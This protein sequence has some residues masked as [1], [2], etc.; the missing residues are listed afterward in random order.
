MKSW[1]KKFCVMTQDIPIATRT[2]LLDQNS[3]ATLSKSVVTE[4][5]KKL[6]E[7]VE[8]ENYK[9]RQKLG[10]RPNTLSR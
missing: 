2:R 4:S 6:K 10:Q 8:T 3:V 1:V 5:N 9:L 7:Q